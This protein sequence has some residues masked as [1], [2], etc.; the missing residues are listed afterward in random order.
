VGTFAVIGTSIASWGFFTKFCRPTLFKLDFLYL[1][2]S[3]DG[4]YKLCI[5]PVILFFEYWY[6]HKCLYKI[7]WL[8]WEM[9]TKP[10]TESWCFSLN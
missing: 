3:R 6:W 9:H 10:L 1:Q 2:H 5:W 8:H 4:C 7:F